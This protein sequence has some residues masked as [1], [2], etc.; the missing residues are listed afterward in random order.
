MFKVG[1]LI[2]GTPDSHDEYRIT[3]SEA[4]M[5]IVMR[6]SP[7]EVWVKLLDHKIGAYKRHIGEVYTMAIKYIRPL[8]PDNRRVIA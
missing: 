6:R 5:E 7:Q 4:R 8:E 1:E 3:T 2:T